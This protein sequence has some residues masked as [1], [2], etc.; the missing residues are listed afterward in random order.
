MSNLT[1]SYI[2]SGYSDYWRGMSNRGRGHGAAFAYYGKNT[3]LRELV[4]QW[5]EESWVNDHDF[6]DLPESV[7][8]DDIRDCIL[9]MLTDSGRKDYESNVVCEFSTNWMSINDIDPDSEDDDCGESPQVII[10]IDWTGHPD[11]T[12]PGGCG[13]R[14]NNSNMNGYCDSCNENG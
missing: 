1:A 3:T 14:A 12:C 4:D 2:F 9:E 13:E 11:Y 7:T 5:V 6:E 8:Q 10:E